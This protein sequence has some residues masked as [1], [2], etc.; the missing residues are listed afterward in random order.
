MHKILI[1]E[2]DDDLRAKI[3]EIL[4]SRLPSMN[5]I[6]A[7]NT[8]TTLAVLWND[9]PDVIIMDIQLGGYSGLKLIEEIKLQYPHITIIINSNYDSIEYRVAA[10]QLGA[11]YFFS[12]KEH[13]L[14]DIVFLITEVSSCSTI[15]PE[16]M[17]DHKKLYA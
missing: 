17:H 14:N 8:S 11:D 2:N 1:I 5:V 12:K 4:L 9:T 7:T 15:S 13:S 16:D 6:E 10:H 3:K